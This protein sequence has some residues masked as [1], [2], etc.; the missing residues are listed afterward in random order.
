MNKY[1]KDRNYFLNYFIAN[2]VLFLLLNIALIALKAD[3][4]AIHFSLVH[5]TLV[6]IGLIFGLIVA[7]AFHNTSHGNIRPRILNT[8]I[9]ELCG[10]IALDG[11]RNFRVG[12]MLHHMHSHDIDKDPHPPHGLTFFEFIR[13][14][15]DRTIEVLI[16]EY[17]KH[18]GDTPTSRKNI[19]NQLLIYKIGFVL[20]LVFWFLLFGPV[21]FI[22]FYTPTFLSYFFGF[23]HLNYISHGLDE[24]GEE[25]MFNHDGGVFYTI[26]NFFT[27]GGYY[28]KN[29][30]KYPGLYNPKKLHLLRSRSASQQISLS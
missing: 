3:V 22:L 12:H 13:T 11:M 20:K 1:K 4:F 19:S 25:V 26:M 8:I 24:D 7:T 30:H 23:A 18:H 6:P 29:H 28:H 15:K 21:G 17:Y 27:S 14:S 5:L 10:A 2:A 9:G 16:D